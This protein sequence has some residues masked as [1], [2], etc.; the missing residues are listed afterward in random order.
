MGTFTAL[1]APLA[2]ALTRERAVLCCALCAALRCCVQPKASRNVSCLGKRPRAGAS[3]IGPAISPI[4][5]LARLCLDG[6]GARRPHNRWLDA[7]RLI[8]PGAL[9]AHS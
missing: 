5:V 7:V 8:T 1:P 9:A 6:A 3:A 4:P 2:L